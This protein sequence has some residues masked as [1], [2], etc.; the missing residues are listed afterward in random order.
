MPKRALLV[1]MKRCHLAC[2]FLARPHL[3][4]T[5]AGSAFI[6]LTWKVVANS[7]ATHGHGKAHRK[8]RRTSAD[9]YHEHFLTEGVEIFVHHKG[10]ETLNMRD[11]QSKSTWGSIQIH[12]GSIE[13]RPQA[14]P[15]ASESELLRLGSRVMES[16]R[17]P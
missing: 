10:A 14:S 16:G 3:L 4:A 1:T 12:Q 17:H 15:G 6:R 5:I 2:E 7:C 9:L 11:T 13:P 8:R